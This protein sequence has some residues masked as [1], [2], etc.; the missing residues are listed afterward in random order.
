MIHRVT[1]APDGKCICR[2]SIAGAARWSGYLGARYASTRVLFVG[3]NHN[4][5]DTGLLKTPAMAEYNR[6]LKVWSEGDAP[7]RE[8]LE[9]M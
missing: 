8:L 3:A 5:G 2:P 4:G 9:P 6:Q 7:S 1:S